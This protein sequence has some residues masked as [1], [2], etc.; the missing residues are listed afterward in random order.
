MM[1]DT[2]VMNV[3]VESTDPDGVARLRLGS[4]CVFLAEVVRGRLWPGQWVRA[5]VHFA[6]VELWP[7]D[8]DSFTIIER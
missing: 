2:T 4:D 5:C 7:Y 1:A 6:Q 8:S 3:V